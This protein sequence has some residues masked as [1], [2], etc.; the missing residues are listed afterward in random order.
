[1]AK[2]GLGSPNMPP[3]TR[4]RITQAGNAA[5]RASGRSHRF[6]GAAAVAA[7]RRGGLARGRRPLDLESVHGLSDREAAERL[8]VS[9][10][11]IA[12]R[13]LAD[14]ARKRGETA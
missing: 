1:M 2:R 14:A 13:R 12:N 4:R 3:E 9:V 8:G 7:G 11:T 6:S 5:M 10:T